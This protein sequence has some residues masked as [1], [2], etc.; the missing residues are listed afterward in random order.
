MVKKKKKR[1]KK[2][3]NILKRKKIKNY[4][5]K[6]NKSKFRSPKKKNKTKESLKSKFKFFINKILTKFK[7]YVEKINIRIAISKLKKIEKLQIKEKQFLES[8]ER[9]IQDRRDLLLKQI[10]QEERSKIVEQKDHLWKL[11]DRFKLI[12]DR[13]KAYK[14]KLRDQ[15]LEELEIRRKSR[16][17]AKAILEQQKAENEVKKKVEERLERY[18]RNMKSIVFQINKRYLARKRSPLRFVDN[19]AENGECFIKNEDA[20]TDKDYLI[21]L[22]INGDSAVERLSNPISIED[23]TDMGNIKKFEPKDIFDASDFIIERLA[24]MFDNERK[25]QKSI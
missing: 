3:K 12:R 18:S 8:K 9:K 15:Q 21:L 23:K 19:I 16:E 6:K 1:N 7:I 4:I 20:P 22:F 24:I 13:Y 2:K 10:K 11:G 5:K 25:F 17:E 14:Q